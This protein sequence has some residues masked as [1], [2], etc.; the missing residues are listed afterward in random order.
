VHWGREGYTE[1]E[2][3]TQ[4]VGKGG[5]GGRRVLCP[6]AVRGDYL[7]LRPWPKLSPTCCYRVQR[8]QL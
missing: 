1:G 6:V 4:R 3:G 5:H 8:W 2:K 7:G